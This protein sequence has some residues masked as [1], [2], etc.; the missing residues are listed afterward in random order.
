VRKLQEVAGKIKGKA[1]ASPQSRPFS[2]TRG[3]EMNDEDDFKSCNGNV[4]PE[5]SDK[6]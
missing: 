6:K 5:H 1:D 3:P 4:E 2:L